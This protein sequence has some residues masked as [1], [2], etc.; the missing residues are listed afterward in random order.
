MEETE[1]KREEYADLQ[2]IGKELELLEQ[3]KDQMKHQITELITLAQNIEDLQRQKEE[4]SLVAVGQG[5][6]TRAKLGKSDKYFVNV[7]ADIIIE[8]THKET[9]E[10]IAKHEKEV[11]NSLEE[12]E[13]EIKKRIEKA[14]TLQRGLQEEDEREK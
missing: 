13:S 3:H 12:I 4:D 2:A 7:G 9:K 11:R 6:F 14:I 5:I 8:K 1:K 10:S